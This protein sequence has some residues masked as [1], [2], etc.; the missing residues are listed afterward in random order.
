MQQTVLH[1]LDDVYFPSPDCTLYR[2]PPPGP[3]RGVP[4]AGA[5]EG[6]AAGRARRVQALGPA[7]GPH[8]IRGEVLILLGGHLPGAQWFSWQN[9]VSINTFM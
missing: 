1:F 7:A 9:N 4:A 3:G 8:R 6:G 2:A 5:G